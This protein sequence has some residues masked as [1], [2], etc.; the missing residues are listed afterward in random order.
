MFFC[1]STPHLNHSNLRQ[2]FLWSCPSWSISQHFIQSLWAV[3]RFP[4]MPSCEGMFFRVLAEGI[5]IKKRWHKMWYKTKATVSWEC[6]DHKST[7]TLQVKFKMLLMEEIPNNHQ[8]CIK[9]RNSWDKLPINW[10]RI[11]S[12]N[13]I[14]YSLV[15]DIAMENHHFFVG[16][17]LVHSWLISQQSLC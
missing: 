1:K 15:K 5:G 16:D 14:E 12:I 11:S 13:S 4:F 6:P 10:C 9:P 3:C 8:G 7:R 2:V 17:T